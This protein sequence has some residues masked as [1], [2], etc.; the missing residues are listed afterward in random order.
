M[1]LDEKTLYEIAEFRCLEECAYRFLYCPIDETNPIELDGFEIILMAYKKHK[2][3][4]DV[5]ERIC[6]LLKDLSNY[7]KTRMRNLSVFTSS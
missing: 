2:D 6:H 1:I 3:R 5:V 7:G 4:A